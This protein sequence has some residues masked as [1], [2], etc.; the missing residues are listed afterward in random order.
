MKSG[1]LVRL[2]LLALVAFALAAWLALART[3]GAATP[4]QG[5]GWAVLDTEQRVLAL[6]PDEAGFALTPERLLR[7][8][9]GASAKAP[10]TELLCELELEL[11]PG[12]RQSSYA[13]LRLTGKGREHRLYVVP[14]AP[15]TAYVGVR[16]PGEEWRELARAELARGA[17]AR[18]PYVLAL[19]LAPG[20][21][22]VTCAGEPLLELHD[23]ELEPVARA[24][25]WTDDAHLARF[26]SVFEDAKGARTRQ[27][28]DFAGAYRTRLVDARR[29]RVGLHRGHALRRCDLRLLHRHL[30]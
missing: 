17:D 20:S 7:L 12:E 3:R 25:L 24:W 14:G 10:K 28:E 1:A 5:P 29:C 23:A 26:A 21:L 15:L 6:E 30:A 4:A 22:T 18:A 27:G 9:G 16:R 13:D 8:E 2:V 11:L 19:T